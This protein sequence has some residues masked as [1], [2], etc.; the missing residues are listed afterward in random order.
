M[1]DAAVVGS[2]LHA[3]AMGGLL[4]LLLAAVRGLMRERL[5]NRLLNAAWLVVAVRLL[6][7]LPAPP[8]EMGW[9]LT[10]WGGVALGVAVCQGTS[11]LRRARRLRRGRKGTLKEGDWQAYQELCRSY[12]VRPVPVF[13][14]EGLEAPCL[15]DGLK[16]FI[17]LPAGLPPSHL[18]LVLAHE[19]CH[20]R[21]RDP[22][23]EA[24]RQGCCAVHWFNPLVW[25]AAWLSRCDGEL[26]CDERV[27]A[28]LEDRERLGYADVVASTE[29]RA[30]HAC[31]RSPRRRRLN[32][33]ITAIIRCVHS[34]RL[35]VVLGTLAGLAA[36]TLSLAA[37]PA[38]PARAEAPQTAVC[39]AVSEAPR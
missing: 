34:G 4:T 33:R 27:T 11:R 10:A 35:A 20:L 25:A 19:I 37:G 3:S 38:L 31:Q 36:L 18:R 24:L 23:W 1:T 21:A 8:V 17:A 14:V 2:L 26:A 30:A 7:L 9:A 6:T 12:G 13:Y 16:P 29:H 32:R 22:L 39:Q 15:S 28:R 5:G